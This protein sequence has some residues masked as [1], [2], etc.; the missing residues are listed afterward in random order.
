MKMSPERN[1][2]LNTAELELSS[3]SSFLS[4]RREAWDVT[5]VGVSVGQSSEIV[6]EQSLH[7]FVCS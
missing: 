3:E 4:F 6:D 1:L 2:C 5:H 7:V